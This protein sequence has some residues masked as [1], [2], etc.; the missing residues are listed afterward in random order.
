M[1][2]WMLK[3]PATIHNCPVCGKQSYYIRHA[4]LLYHCDGSDN[5]PCHLQLVRG[6]VTF[7]ATPR[8]LGIK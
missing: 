8:E 7:H 6:A 4:D 2:D 1:S 5:W 3:T